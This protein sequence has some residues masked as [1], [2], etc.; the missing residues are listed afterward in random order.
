MSTPIVLIS[1]AM[2]VPSSFYGPLVAAFEER[3]WT[4]RAL[5]R[6]GFERDLPRASRRHDWSYAD[7]VADTQG[8]VDAARAEDPDR[9]VV[10]FG[11][12]LGGQLGGAVQIGPRPADGLVL[13]GVSLPHFRHYPRIGLPLAAMALSMP[14]VGL[15]RGYVPK[16]WF[17]GPGARTMMSEWA[18]VVRT[19]RAPYAVNRRIT[20]PTLAVHLA[21]DGFSITAAAHRFE[22]TLVEPAALT[23]W[24]YTR[25]LLPEGGTTHHVLWARHP[26]PVV[27]RVVRWWADQA[28]ASTGGQEQ[29]RFRS[30]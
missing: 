15:V 1:P 8:A 25:D 11:H 20:L 28:N 27:D 22:R 16:P 3:G 24:E 19:G 9:P 26:G 18:R 17:G 29:T 23:S 2:A 30:P 10:I 6:R 5:P 12:S 21:G 7:E 4:A 14:L 13:V